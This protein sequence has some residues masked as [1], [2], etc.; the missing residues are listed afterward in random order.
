M[1]AQGSPMSQMGLVTSNASPHG[2]LRDC[3]RDEG[4]PMSTR[5]SAMQNRVASHKEWLKARLELL[6]AEKEFTRQRDAL[7]RR[8][9]SMPWERVEKSYQFEGLNGTLHS[10]TRRSLRRMLSADRLSLHVRPR[11]GRRVQVMLLLG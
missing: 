11:L 2:G 5:R 1:D 9:M 4:R 6:D 8:R 10:L 7:T 3:T